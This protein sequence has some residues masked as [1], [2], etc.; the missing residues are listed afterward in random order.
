M[1]KWLAGILGAIIAGLVVWWVTIQLGNEGGSKPPPEQAFTFT[2]SPNPAK[3]GQKVM[4]YLSDARPGAMVYYNGR[5][6]PKVDLDY[7]KV[8]RVTI[9]ANA[10]S[11]YFELKWNGQSVR[12]SKKFIVLD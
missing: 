3:R 2:V 11:G 9:P 5:P 8:F 10:K 6:L 12:A 4:L 7:S 1:G